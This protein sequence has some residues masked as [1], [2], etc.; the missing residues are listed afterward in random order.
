[1]NIIKWKLNFVSCNFGLKSNLWLQI[2]LPLRGR[3][4]CNHAFDFSPNCTPLSSITIMNRW[5]TPLMLLT[6]RTRATSGRPPLESLISTSDTN[7]DNNNMSCACS[8]LARSTR[9]SACIGSHHYRSRL[10]I[11]SRRNCK[12]NWYKSD[13][14]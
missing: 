2:A 7:T 9:T 11:G 10:C 1:M 14:S 12:I 13:I 6:L 3:A 4:I 5:L 8:L